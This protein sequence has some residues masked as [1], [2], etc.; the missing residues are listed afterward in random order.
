MKLLFQHNEHKIL[1][2]RSLASAQMDVDGS[3]EDVL[4]GFIN[5]QLR[6]FDLKGKAKNPDGTIDQVR[7]HFDIGFF[8]DTISLYYNEELIETQKGSL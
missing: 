3:V 7:V 6:A 8:E 4:N 2:T 5:A 1:V